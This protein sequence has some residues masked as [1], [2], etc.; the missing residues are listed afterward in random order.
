MSFQSTNLRAW[1]QFAPWLSKQAVISREDVHYGL[2]IAGE[3]ELSLLPQIANARILD[4]G[5]GTGE[6]C[7]ALAARGAEVVG[8]EPTKIFY[9]TARASIP[10]H[11][12]VCVLNRRWGSR[13]LVRFA[14]FD[15]VLFIGSS[16]FLRFD[17][18]FFRTL[19][20]LTHQRSL[21][22]VAR[23]HPFWT[24]LFVHENARAKTQSYFNNGRIDHLLYEGCES[25]FARCH[26]SIG[27]LTDQFGCNGWSLQKLVEPPVVPP[28]RAPFWVRGCY[29]DPAL[30]RRM[31]LI[32]MTLILTFTPRKAQSS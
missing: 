20:E 13:S 23:V 10:L 6:N 28:D 9:E 30:S 5:C 8:I 7:H 26:H 4:V 31:Q 2:C 11:L 15:I 27:Y 14:P 29:N 3:R 25:S 32:P 19:S 16:E 12:N 1:S 21:I 18:L 22:L 17:D 24:T